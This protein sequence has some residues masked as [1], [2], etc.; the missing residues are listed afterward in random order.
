MS[1][2]VTAMAAVLTQD[3]HIKVKR[4]Q[5]QMVVLDKITLLMPKSVISPNPFTDDSIRKKSF[6][7]AKA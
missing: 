3:S 6:P 2:N 7:H 5:A 4:R 1:K